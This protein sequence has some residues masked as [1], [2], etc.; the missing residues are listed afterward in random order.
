[1]MNDAPIPGIANASLTLLNS[2][3]PHFKGRLATATDNLKAALKTAQE[4]RNE[5]NAEVCRTMLARFRT[6][7]NKYQYI[8][9]LMLDHV[10]LTNGANIQAVND[11]RIRVAG[12]EHQL[13][14]D[15]RTVLDAHDATEEEDRAERERA[16]RRQREMDLEEEEAQLNRER[17]RERARPKTVRIESTLKP[18]ELT[19]DFTPIECDEWVKKLTGYF[20]TCYIDTLEVVGQQTHARACIDERLMARLDAQLTEDLPVL[21]PRDDANGDCWVKVIKSEFLEIYPLMDRRYAAMRTAQKQS[22]TFVEFARRAK[23]AVAQAN[24]GAAGLT[25]DEILQIIF[26]TGAADEALRKEFLKEE[27]P[28]LEDLK[29]LGRAHD[30]VIKGVKTDEPAKVNKVNSQG[31]NKDK[32]KGGNGNNGNKK[33]GESLIAE[34]IRVHK[35]SMEG[36]CTYC[37]E[38]SHSSRDCTKKTDFTCGKCGNKHRT[39]VCLRDAISKVKE[40]RKGGNSGGA[41]A[42]VV[43]SQAIEHKQAQ[44]TSHEPKAYYPDTPGPFSAFHAQANVVRVESQKDQR[45][46]EEVANEAA[47]AARAMAMSRATP[48]LPL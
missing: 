36:R 31:G 3:K 17:E 15:A 11:E 46:N 35:P 41:R 29:R 30:R 2:K 40:H 5:A 26:V 14:S 20:K 4:H 38:S 48:D 28:T 32:G 16:Q 33:S 8:L 7:T 9:N 25:K 39:D 19:A 47:R 10:D 6:Q 42:R 43:E 34:A 37:G 13:V 1:M 18:K 44:Q 23:D 24:I 21:P 27:N 22:E 12:I 45:E